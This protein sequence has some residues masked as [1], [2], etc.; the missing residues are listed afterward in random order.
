[1]KINKQK[2][3]LWYTAAIIILAVCVFGGYIIYHFTAQQ[4]TTNLS[5]EQIRKKFSCNRV[6]ANVM[7][8]DIYCQFPELYR[9]GTIT[10]IEL[11]KGLKCDQKEYIEVATHPC[12]DK[13]AY[14]EYKKWLLSKDKELRANGFAE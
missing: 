7:Q 1:M 8:T 11:Q 12:L 3:V 9:T 2:T 4:N 13:K 5:D 14:D 10:D 6:T